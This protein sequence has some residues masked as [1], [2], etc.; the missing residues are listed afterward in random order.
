MPN[1]PV[2]NPDSP[3]AIMIDAAVSTVLTHLIDNYVCGDC[4][5]I[6]GKTRELFAHKEAPDG[7]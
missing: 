3:A 5:D 4:A 7:S 2:L 1:T 6:L